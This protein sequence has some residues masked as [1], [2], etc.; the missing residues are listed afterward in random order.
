MEVFSLKLPDLPIPSMNCELTFAPYLEYLEQQKETTTSQI[1]KSYLTSISDLLHANTELLNPI[2]D[3]SILSKHKELSELLRITHLSQ[4]EGDNNLHAFG[5]PVGDGKSMSCFSWSEE[6][7]E[8]IVKANNHFKPHTFADTEELH[9]HIYIEILEGCYPEYLK[10]KLPPQMSVQIVDESGNKKR[11]FKLNRRSNFAKVVPKDELPEMRQEWADYANGVLASFEDIEQPIPVSKFVIQGF[12]LFSV[13]ENTEEMALSELRATA[14]QMHNYDHEHTYEKMRDASLSLLGGDGFE[15]GFVPFFKVNSRYV[16]H[17][18]FADISIL[19]SRM[20]KHMS[21]EQLEVA[22]TYLSDES[23]KDLDKHAYVSFNTGEATCDE[24]KMLNGLLLKEGLKSVAL[25]P[26]K[27]QDKVIGVIEIGNTKQDQIDT[28]ILNKA[29]AAAPY[30]REYFVFNTRYFEEFLKSFVMQ[31]YT[32]IQPS[33]SWKFTEETWKLFSTF[34]NEEDIYKASTPSVRFQNLHPFYGAVDY[35][36]SSVK[37]LQ[38][39]HSDYLLQLDYLKTLLQEDILVQNQAVEDFIVNI[40]RWEHKVNSHMDFE[41]EYELRRFLDIEAIQFLNNLYKNDL[42][43]QNAYEDYQESA[44]SKDGIFHLSHNDY[45]QS[46]Q[47]LN[48]VLK[49]ELNKAE[50]KL[51]SLVPHYFEKFQTDGVEY[52]LYAGHSIDPKRDLPNN[53]VDIVAEWQIDTMLAMANVARA[54]R[55]KLSVPLETTQLILVH[56]NS[57]DISYRIDEKHFDVEG[58]Y[59]IRYEVVKKRIDKVKLLGSSERLTQPNTIA[60]VYAHK[61]N[62]RPYLERVGQLI[63]KGSLKRDIEFLDLEQLQ[64]VGNLKAIRVHINNTQL[65]NNIKRQVSQEV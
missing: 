60:I 15:V 23:D 45:E 5:L 4:A 55:A 47:T 30:Y 31:R 9:R 54:N 33:V 11:Y 12:F 17:S 27:H 43:E 37:Q 2:A 18:S 52:S 64:G 26:V 32:S 8:F 58:S 41:D 49:D 24:E 63:E 14:A 28:K 29:I 20:S 62:C 16:Y 38:A 65:Q 53:A 21:K 57:V 6:F 7:K 61:D 34:N 46:L 50:D 51:Q 44:A 59:S 40:E 10:E 19:F 39:I 25:V 13:V 36:N 1:Y 48:S 56:E 42:L 35:R 3:W 22:F